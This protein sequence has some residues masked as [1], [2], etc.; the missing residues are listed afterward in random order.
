MNVLDR[1]SRAR[2]FIFDFDGTLA[3]NLD[4]PDMRR[5]V[6]EFTTA[7][8]VPKHAFAD[9][10]IVEIIEAAAVWLGERDDTAAGSYH[11]SAHQ[12]ITDFELAAAATTAPFAGVRETLGELKDLGKRLGVV[13]RNCNLAVRTVFEDI[14][15]YCEAVLARD[16][17]DFLKPDL[18]HVTQAL[19]F[20]DVEPQQAVMVGDGQMDMRVGRKLG[21]ACVGVLSGSSDTQRLR[22]A[23]AD[24]ILGNV[25]ELTDHVA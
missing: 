18:R 6:I 22:D 5:Q 23:G 19:G 20:L 15:H 21:M 14:D 9:L 7:H 3:P 12:L 8:G 16:T 11:Q 1:L 25:T 10:Y 24:L 2:S 17:T 4:L 13:T